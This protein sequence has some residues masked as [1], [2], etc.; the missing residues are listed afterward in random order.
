MKKNKYHEQIHYDNSRAK[1][2][3]YSRYYQNGANTVRQECKD[4][5]RRP[6]NMQGIRKMGLHVGKGNYFLDA[7]PY[8]QTESKPDPEQQPGHVRV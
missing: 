6:A 7:M 5:S 3:E 8:K 1:P 4:K 2:G